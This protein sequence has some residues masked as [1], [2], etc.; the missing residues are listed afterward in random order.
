VDDAFLLGKIS[1]TAAD[2]GNLTPLAGAV[3]DGL[4][5]IWLFTPGGDPTCSIT[6]RRDLYLYSDGLENSTPATHSCYSATSSVAPF[7]ATKAGMG[8]GLDPGSWQRKVANKAY[9]NNPNLD[10]IDIP[11][12][13]R[14]V[15]NISLLFDFVPSASARSSV[16]PSEVDFGRGPHANA[17]L[18]SA[19]DSNG[20]A[21]FKGLS[22]VSFG[23]YFEAKQINGVVTKFP[24]PG[25]TN[26]EPTLSCVDQLDLNRIVEVFGRTVRNNDPQFS[27]AELARRDVN[28]DLVID[29]KDYSLATQNFGKCR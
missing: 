1:D 20:V 22:T 17:I 28:N 24:M 19:L 16:L 21:F 29:I 18:S 26:P 23:S 13:L 10:F 2:L 14:P 25:D 12:F 27:G 4:D 8:F 3:C 9:N 6:V 7:D 11:S 15:V 5:D